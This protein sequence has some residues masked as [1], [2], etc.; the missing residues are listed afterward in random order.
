VTKSLKATYA[1]KYLI[2]SF[3]Q[4]SHYLKI[5]AV[6]LAGAVTWLLTLRLIEH[7]DK[8]ASFPFSIECHLLRF[9]F[10]ASSW[11]T[12][13][14]LL[15]SEVMESPQLGNCNLVGMRWYKLPYQ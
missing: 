6:P 4:F 3:A 14:K 8:A 5:N 10:S 7:S 9:T 12:I 13:C 1:W 15:A 11:H 2:E